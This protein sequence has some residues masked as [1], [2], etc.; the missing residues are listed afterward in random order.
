MHP[1]SSSEESIYRSEIGHRLNLQQ[2]FQVRDRARVAS[3]RLS[4]L[5][6]PRFWTHEVLAR[7][8]ELNEQRDRRLRAAAG[9]GR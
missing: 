2:F 5:T 3:T 1:P 9:P 4:E 6:R 7:A 8:G